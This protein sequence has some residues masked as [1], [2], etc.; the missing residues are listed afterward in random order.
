ML[1]IV[2]RAEEVRRALAGLVTDAEL[3]PYSALH[4]IIQLVEKRW[5]SIGQPACSPGVQSP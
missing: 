1:H 3:S 4:H 2:G 5:P